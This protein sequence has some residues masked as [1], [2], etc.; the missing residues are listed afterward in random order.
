MSDGV[1]A[2]PPGDHSRFQLPASQAKQPPRRF[3]TSPKTSTKLKA[4]EDF[5]IDGLAA[6]EWR[7]APVSG[8]LGL[9]W[10]ATASLWLAWSR[11]VR[12]LELPTEGPVML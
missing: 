8:H 1:R 6:A 5:Q 7:P 4:F 11:T 2:V 12:T 10:S 3:W 9:R